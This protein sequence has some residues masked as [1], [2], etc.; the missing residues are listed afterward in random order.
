[1]R[2]MAGKQGGMG[3]VGFIMVAVGIILVAVLGM[4]VVPPYIHSAQI[5]QIFRSIASDPA[6][7]S[8]SIKEIRDSYDKRA[9][10]NY[11][12]D[13]AAEDIV[14]ETGDGRLRLSTNYS[15][16]VPLVAN[17]TLLLE[18]NPSSS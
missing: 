16:K 5:A 15:V 6:M 10:V 2:A 18:F 14:I 7:Q 8:A 12:T 9:N 13:V 11:I 3:M 4:K 17:I 1:M